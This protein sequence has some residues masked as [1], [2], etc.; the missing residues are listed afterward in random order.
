[1]SNKKSSLFET[2]VRNK[3]YST[4]Y[5]LIVIGIIGILIP[6]IIGIVGLINDTEAV[7]F[8]YIS[9]MMISE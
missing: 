8:L 9:P 4:F 3:I 1:M 5:A 7:A 2:E 6:F